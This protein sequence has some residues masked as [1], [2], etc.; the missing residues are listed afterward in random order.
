MPVPIAIQLYTVRDAL[1]RDFAGVVRQIADIGYVGVEPFGFSG[2]T[3]REAG[4]L[5]RELGL[6]V[7]GAHTAMPLD[8]R[9]NQVLDTVA[10]FGCSRIVSGLGPDHFGT[11]DQIKR[12][13]D[14]FNQADAVAVAHGL[15]FGIHNHWWEFEPV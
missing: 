12:S 6:Q 14:Q 8:E 2:T 5:F 7:P 10:A 1:A 3:P 11:L 4:Q 15:T 13:C 9:Q